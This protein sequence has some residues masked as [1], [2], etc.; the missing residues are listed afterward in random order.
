RQYPDSAAQA[1]MIDHRYRYWNRKEFETAEKSGM[2]WSDA[3]QAARDKCER[4]RDPTKVA[5]A[6]L[7]P[8]LPDKIRQLETLRWDNILTPEEADELEELHRRYPDLAEKT[9]E[10]VVGRLS[11]DQDRREANRRTGY[12]PG[13]IKEDGWP[14]FR[15]G[16]ARLSKG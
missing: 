5:S 11:Y 7:P 10:F 6:S 1:D 14:R 16:P 9:R 2:K 3:V 12:D 4:L 8:N 13:P 15:T